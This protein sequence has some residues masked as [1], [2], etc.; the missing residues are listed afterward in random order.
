MNLRRFNPFSSKNRSRL[1]V[2]IGILF[3]LGFFTIIFSAI[4]SQNIDYRKPKS[5]ALLKHKIHFKTD[6]PVDEIEIIDTFDDLCAVKV[7]AC[8]K[9]LKFTYHR[10]NSG[11]K[12]WVQE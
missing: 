6:C 12:K 11:G 8:G 3:M 10:Q 4:V 2:A 5:I 7:K 9:I 1:Y